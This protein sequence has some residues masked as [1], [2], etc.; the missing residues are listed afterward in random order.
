MLPPTSAEVHADAQFAKVLGCLG[1]LNKDGSLFC[2]PPHIATETWVRKD[3][4]W[5]FKEDL[6][7]KLLREWPDEPLAVHPSGPEHVLSRLGLKVVAYNTEDEP[8]T[9]RDHRRL[10]MATTHH[11]YRIFRPR[12]PSLAV[13]RRQ[14]VNWRY[15]G[16]EEDLQISGRAA[17]RPGSFHA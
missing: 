11:G 15:W 6:N 5:I 9:K 3:G 7:L 10:R 1:Y 13:M 14:L 16:E 12:G 4:E 17:R 2:G 8:K